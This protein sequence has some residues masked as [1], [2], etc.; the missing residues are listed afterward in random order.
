MLQ[1]NSIRSQEDIL[2][3]WHRHRKDAIRVGR[4]RIDEAIR[5][6]LTVSAMEV[7]NDQYPFHGISLIFKSIVRS[8]EKQ[9]ETDDR[10][11]I[12]ALSQL[13]DRLQRRMYEYQ[14]PGFFPTGDEEKLMFQ[15]SLVELL[16]KVVV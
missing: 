8:M 4:Q 3:Q 14:V 15:K 13:A 5:A 10:Q 6:E 12:N 16:M 9:L 1:N 2:A 7:I 11:L